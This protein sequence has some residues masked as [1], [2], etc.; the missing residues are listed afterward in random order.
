LPFA[1]HLFKLCTNVVPTLFCSA[2]QASFDY[3]SSFKIYLYTAPVELLLPIELRKQI[4]TSKS[5]YPIGMEKKLIRP[6]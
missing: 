3:Y 1:M 6:I 4:Q 2:K 5:N